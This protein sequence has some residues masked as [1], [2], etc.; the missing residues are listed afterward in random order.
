MYVVVKVDDSERA[1]ERGS[2]LGVVANRL[3]SHTYGQKVRVLLG[4]DRDVVDV[5]VQVGILHTCTDIRVQIVCGSCKG[6]SCG[7]LG[8]GLRG[9]RS[10]DV[11]CAYGLLCM[12]ADICTV[13]CLSC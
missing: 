7:E 8:S 1:V 10:R 4:E 13:L 2:V 11:E 6:G 3:Q 5:R 12:D 9:N